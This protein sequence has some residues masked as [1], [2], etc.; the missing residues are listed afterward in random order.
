M[1]IK[2]FQRDLQKGMTLHDALQ[3]HQLT[4]KEAF[5]QA[6]KP[7]KHK[8]TPETYHASQY[9]QYR[10]GHY[11]LRKNVFSKSKGRPVTRMFGTYTTLEDAVKMREAQ[12]KIGWKV[13]HV[14]RLC[15]ELGI[16]RCTYW[17]NRVRYH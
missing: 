2:A 10:D 15:E 12:K 14:D 6:E 7:I 13:T 5:Q 1:S 3:K 17:N 11:Y 9:I 4:L 16:K 8:G